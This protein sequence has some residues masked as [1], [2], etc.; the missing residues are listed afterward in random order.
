MMSLEFL[1]DLVRVCVD[2]ALCFF[3]LAILLFVSYRVLTDVPAE[4]EFESFV[5]MAC[6]LIGYLVL[7]SWV[8]TLIHWAVTSKKLNVRS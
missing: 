3:I 5:R 1:K 6:S 4:G 2:I 7:A 8:L